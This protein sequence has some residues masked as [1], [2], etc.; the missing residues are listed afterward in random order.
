MPQAHGGS[1]ESRGRYSSHSCWLRT[2]PVVAQMRSIASSTSRSHSRIVSEPLDTP[3]M[4]LLG[5]KERKLPVL[6]LGLIDCPMG[7][8]ADGSATSQSRTVLSLP[9]L[10]SL[11][12]SRLYVSDTTAS[13][14]PVRAAP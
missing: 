5:L 9:P 10:A 12:P 2:F 1:Y 3:S 4:R 8:A 7:P 11:A 6:A 13:V 14:C